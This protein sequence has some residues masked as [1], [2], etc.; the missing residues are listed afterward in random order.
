V[1][2]LA[3]LERSK[4]KRGRRVYLDVMQNV[5]GRHAVPPYVLRAVPE[6]TVSTPLS[7]REV[8][9]D[10]QLEKYNLKTIFRRLAALKVDPFAELADSYNCAPERK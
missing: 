1:P 3:T 4:A 6:A 5:R 8:T 7:W 2:K 10:L 9:Q